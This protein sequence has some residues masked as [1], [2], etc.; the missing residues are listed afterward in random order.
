MFDQLIE[1][2]DIDDSFNWDDAFFFDPIIN[3]NEIIK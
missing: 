2:R 3:Q 1:R